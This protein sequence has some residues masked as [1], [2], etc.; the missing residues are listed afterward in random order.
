MVT[1]RGSQI[2]SLEKSCRQEEADTEIVIYVSD[3]ISYGHEA[4]VKTGDT[5]IVT[6]VLVHYTLD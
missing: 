1:V 3:C 5:D 4:V 6:L 2:G